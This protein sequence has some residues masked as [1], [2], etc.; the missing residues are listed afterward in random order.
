MPATK[1]PSS[2][3]PSEQ[4]LQCEAWSSDWPRTLLV[5]AGVVGSAIAEAHLARG[6]NIVL[7]DQNQDLLL[8]REQ[9]WKDQPFRVSQVD[10]SLLGMP[11]IHVESGIADP[12]IQPPIVIESIVEKLDAKRDLFRR[13]QQRFGPE[14]TLCSNTSTLLIDEI[15][16][17]LPAPEAVCGL[18]FFMPV[19]LRG[20]AEVISGPRTHPTVAQI[21][22]EH[23]KRIGKQP[24]QCRDSPG[25]IVNRMLSPYLNQ[26]LLLL[27]HG[28]KESQIERA[29]IAYGMPLSPLELI[30]WIGTN[31]MYYAGR[32]FLNA[33]PQRMSPSPVVP[34]LVKQKRFGRSCGAGLYDYDSAGHR[35]A[36]L[37]DQA[38]S[39]IESYRVSSDRI[40]DGQVLLLLSIPMWIESQAL[41]REGV[42]DSIED[43]DTAMAGGL[44]F[45]SHAPWSAFFNELEDSL[46][47]SCCD[48]WSAK[49][50]SMVMP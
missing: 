50:R 44:G 36:E 40:D 25:F 16:E 29:A 10:S 37:S 28:A 39:I 11:A 7:A 26:A 21:A 20:G 13:L 46:I 30:D 32:S 1:P 14:L 38:R 22:S 35:S 18:H 2:K 23:A 19:H 9:A 17:S 4:T 12:S 5:G 34:A 33:F 42:A 49:F 43:I 41:L 3:I 47:Q 45:N 8:D 6:V 24:I 27:C 48:Q 31:T 15:A